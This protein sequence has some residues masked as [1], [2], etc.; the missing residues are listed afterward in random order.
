MLKVKEARGQE[1]EREQGEEKGEH[2]KDW[3]EEQG[4]ENDIIIFL[5]ET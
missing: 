5:F 4:R 3:R 1:F 2:G